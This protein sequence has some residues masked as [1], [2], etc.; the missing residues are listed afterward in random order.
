[1]MRMSTHMR[2]RHIAAILLLICFSGCRLLS[3]G[4]SSFDSY[5][6][7]QTTSL[8]VDALNLMG[9]ATE[10]YHLHQTAV[11]ELETNVQKIYEYEKH[12]PKNEFTTAQWELLA[13]SSGHLLGGFFMKWRTETKLNL[14]YI[15]EKKKQVAE[16]FDQIAELESK[17]IK[18]SHT[19][20]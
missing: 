20:N 6:Y 10:D 9:K 3:P 13:D 12:R 7:L 17:K 15:R 4:I 18:P 14:V 11:Q 16:A 2:L 8:K 5:A 1:M 19:K